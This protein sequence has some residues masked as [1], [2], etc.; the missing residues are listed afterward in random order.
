MP[1][2]QHNHR[3]LT[4]KA[5]PSRIGIP[6]GGTARKRGRLQSITGFGPQIS[7]LETTKHAAMWPRGKPSSTQLT[8]C[9]LNHAQ[10]EKFTK[11]KQENKQ[12]IMCIDVISLPATVS[13]YDVLMGHILTRRNDHGRK[14]SNMMR[15]TSCT[16]GYFLVRPPKLEHSL[17][18]RAAWPHWSCLKMIS[19]DCAGRLTGWPFADPD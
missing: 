9:L 15:S 1:E 17:P 19:C 14:E 8:S 13:L 7:L 11:R 5:E 6:P 10:I 2:T 12:T 4:T 16:E 18:G 3:R